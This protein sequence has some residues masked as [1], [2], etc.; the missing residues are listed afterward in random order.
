MYCKTSKC[1]L[2]ISLL[3]S[4]FVAIVFVFNSFGLAVQSSAVGAQDTAIV[5]ES[6]VLRNIFSRIYEGDFASAKE[7]IKQADAG[8]LNKQ[9]DA[10]KAG[11][12]ERISQIV[13]DFDKLVV[14]IPY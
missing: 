6:A 14:Y 12:F 11:S 7:L 2:K 5:S 10:A 4:L 9:P 3:V 13:A 8:E 1:N